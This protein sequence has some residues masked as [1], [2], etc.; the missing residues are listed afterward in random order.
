MPILGTFIVPHPPLIVSEIG[1]GQQNKIQKTIDAYKQVAQLIANMKPDTIIFTTPHSDS[2]ADYFHISSGKTASGSFKD[3]GAPQVNFT[4]NYADDLTQ[5]IS[6]L[7][8]A[9]GIPA[10]TLG[11]RNKTLDHGTMVPLYFINQAYQNYNIVRISLSGLPLL[12]HYQ[13][14]KCIASAVQR[15]DR[16]V[17]LV[18]SG[19]LSHKL[20]LDGPY[21]FAKE[22][23]QFDKQVTQA[24]SIG[25]FTRLLSF[26]ADFCEAAAECGLKSFVIMAGSLDGK[27]V[28]P[29]LISYEGPFGVGYAVA[30]FEVIGDDDSHRYDLIYEKQESK[31]IKEVKSHEDY[32]V[33]LARQSL[34]HYIKTK[35][36][37]HRP[38]N[39]SEEL[40]TKKAGVFVSIKKDGSL[41]GCIGTI[42]PT[43]DCIADEI[44]RNAVSSGTAD[45]RFEP[46][47]ENEISRLEISV[48]VLSEAKPIKSV[49]ELDV[50]RYGVIV[51]FKDRCGLLLPNLDGVTTVEDQVKIALQKG[52]I[53]AKEKYTMERFEV[54]RHK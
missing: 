48:D 43:T 35:K 30:V 3:F 29:K 20:T 31:R 25:D 22:G 8:T 14:G 32:Y 21:G 17:V 54:V 27:E 16:K 5:I 10:G 26:D 45:P 1:R 7:A 37:M 42:M 51:R 40:T 4:V 44:I 49:F 9:A 53:S 47:R 11:E 24:I 12:S 46:I 13:M 36:R 33:S 18:A 19:D 52:G 41:R 2:Y 34:E 39:L 50:K 6:S 23:E 38:D 28:K 15:A